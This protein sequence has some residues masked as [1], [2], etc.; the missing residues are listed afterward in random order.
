MINLE[1]IK[2]SASPHLLTRPA[3]TPYFDS[4]FKNFFSCLP[5]PWELIKIYFFSIKK[6][7][8]WVQ[9]MIDNYNYWDSVSKCIKMK[10][11]LLN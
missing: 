5:P 9:T 3:S 11:F 8:G 1:K 6:G 10:I 2:L 7:V 4:L